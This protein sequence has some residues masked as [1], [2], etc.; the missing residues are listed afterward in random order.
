[1]NSVF[2]I[3]AFFI[4]ENAKEYIN[5]SELMRHAAA[6][7]LYMLSAIISYSTHTLSTI[8]PDD[9]TFLAIW[10]I[11]MLTGCLGAFIAQIFLILIFWTLSK[12]VEVSRNTHIE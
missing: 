2:E 8:Q 5:L 12:N 1:M 6:F 10:M 3:R 11:G 9:E 7:G 4:K